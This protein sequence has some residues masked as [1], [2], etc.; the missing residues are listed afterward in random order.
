MKL[1][2]YNVIFLE[3]T[4]RTIDRFWRCFCAC[5]K[6]KWPKHANAKNVHSFI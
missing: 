4:V 2:T 5:A 3:N 1:V 6:K